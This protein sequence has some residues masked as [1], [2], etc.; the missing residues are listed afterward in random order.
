MV[1]IIF[2]IILSKRILFF[3]NFDIYICNIESI[4]LYK[5]YERSFLKLILT[6]DLFDIFYTGHIVGI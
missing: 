4:F 2:G 5:R 6:N 3:R 1:T